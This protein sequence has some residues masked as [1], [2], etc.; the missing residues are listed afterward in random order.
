MHL[1]R[2]S[3]QPIADSMAPPRLPPKIFLLIISHLRP[4]SRT[5]LAS[6]CL[7]SKFLFK[8]A[9]RQLYKHLNF[10]RLDDLEVDRL[11]SLIHSLPTSSWAPLVHT[12]EVDLPYPITDQQL[13]LALKAMINLKSLHFD[14]PTMP[15]MDEAMRDVDF[16]LK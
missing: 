9:R 7:T 10:H 12:L 1:S 5:T 4:T 13:N 2:R 14:T 16:K 6:L 15:I 3:S 11:L 8:P